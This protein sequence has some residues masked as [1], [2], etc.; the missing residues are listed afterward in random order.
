VKAI[1]IKGGISS[2]VTTKTFTKNSGGGD[3]GQN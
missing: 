1:A 2:A 3:L